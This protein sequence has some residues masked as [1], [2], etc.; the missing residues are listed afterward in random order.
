MIKG[1]NV[2]VGDVT[3]GAVTIRVKND[4]EDLS[5]TITAV[6]NELYSFQAW[7]GTLA[8]E[9][10]PYEGTLAGGMTISADFIAD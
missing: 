7:G 3:N 4:P 8:G 6:P 2:T 10:N 1:I 5:V 9:A